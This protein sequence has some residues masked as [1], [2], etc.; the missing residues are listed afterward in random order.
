MTRCNKP[1]WFYG[2][3]KCG[4]IP[5][6]TKARVGLGY[7]RQ[8]RLFTVREVAVILR[9]RPE[10][11]REQIRSGKM[12]AVRFGQA[13]FIHSFELNRWMGNSPRGSKPLQTLNM[14]RKHGKTAKAPKTD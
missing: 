10:W 8:V 7:G 3:S 13:Y 9:H 5:A 14:R 6:Y 1:G 4:E 11:V 2:R 12:S